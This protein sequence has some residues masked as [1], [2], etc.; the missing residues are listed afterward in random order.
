MYDRQN[1]RENARGEKRNVGA[2][3]HAAA[4]MVA[5]IDVRTYNFLMDIT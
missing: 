2:M 1:I 3:L 4:G 5:K